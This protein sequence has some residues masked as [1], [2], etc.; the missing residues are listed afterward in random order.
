M[1]ENIN[2]VK[3]KGGRFTEETSL[4]DC[5]KRPFNI[6]YGTNGSGKSTLAKALHDYGR[7][8]RRDDFELEFIPGNNGVRCENVHVFNED[9][10][11]SRMKVTEDTGNNSLNTIVM[12]GE[13]IETNNSVEDIS[14]QIAELE[15]E[16]QVQEAV[17]QENDT[18]ELREK[19]GRSLRNNDFDLGKR[20][21]QINERRTAYN[22]PKSKEW[23]KH[24]IENKD[25]YIYSSIGDMLTAVNADIQKI[26]DSKGQETYSWDHSKAEVPFDAEA[27]NALLAK[28]IQRPELDERDE[29]LVGMTEQMM[30]ETQ[31]IL[32]GMRGV[33]VCPICR[34]QVSEEHRSHILALISQN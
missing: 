31:Q 34:Q 33:G 18:D 10:I 13:Q 28:T 30:A 7:E 15:K 24:I 9:F 21:Q 32:S 20:L 29:Y 1:L 14:K 8:D 16:I 5:L 23:I 3:I 22:I 12:F 25:D 2:G 19:L 4:Q 6:I 26:Q 27:A 17:R 11:N